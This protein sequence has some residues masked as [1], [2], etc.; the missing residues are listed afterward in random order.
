VTTSR[1]WQAF[2]PVSYKTAQ[3]GGSLELFVMQPSG[4]GSG[5]SFEV[6]GLTLTR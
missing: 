4:A 3:S 5:D 2:P 6:D 1:A